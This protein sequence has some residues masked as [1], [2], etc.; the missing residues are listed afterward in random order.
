MN[1]LTFLFIASLF[2]LA[3][4][5]IADLPDMTFGLGE[6]GEITCIADANPPANVTWERLTGNASAPMVE[7]MDVEG[8]GKSSL[9]FPK[10]KT[11]DGGEYRCT[12][13]NKFGNVSQTTTVFVKGITGKTINYHNYLYF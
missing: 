2:P 9:L 6:G 7:D 5:K 11:E 4:P 3:K 13:T 8:V 10:L 1:S 12:A